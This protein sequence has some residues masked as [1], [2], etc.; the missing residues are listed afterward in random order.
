MCSFK[1]HSDR[2]DRARMENSNR[3]GITI[4]DL[5]IVDWKYNT[6]VGDSLCVMGDAVLGMQYAVGATASGGAAMMA[7]AAMSRMLRPF[8]HRPWA[9]TRC[10]APCLHWA[11]L[12]VMSHIS[13]PPFASPLQE[14]AGLPPP[15]QTDA[16]VRARQ[17]KPSP[18]N[19]YRIASPPDPPAPPRPRSSRP[20]A[21]IINPSPI[22]QE[23]SP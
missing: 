23:I 12:H 10:L 17:E 11:R 20:I 9:C 15:C 6:D 18:N 2:L 19:L 21:C 3:K 14:S 5:Q 22:P 1:N 16:A 4:I 8:R 13:A 7:D